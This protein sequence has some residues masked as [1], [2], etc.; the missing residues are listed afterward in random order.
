MCEWG[1]LEQ[2]RITAGAS[3]GISQDVVDSTSM[4]E[5]REPSSGWN[6]CVDGSNWCKRIHTLGLRYDG[7]HGEGGAGEGA[8]TK[9]NGETFLEGVSQE[10]A[11]VLIG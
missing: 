9:G 3:A 10:E 4:W 1:L 2:E 5:K 11:S 6:R 8:R 7:G